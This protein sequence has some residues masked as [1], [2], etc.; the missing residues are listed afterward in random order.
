VRLTA[1]A[2]LK[3]D[4]LEAQL[5]DGDP[6]VTVQDIITLQGA[7]DK[8]VPPPKMQITVKYADAADT[9]PLDSAA[10]DNLR[11][12]R[13]CGWVPFDRDRVAKCYGCSWRSGDDFDS[14]WQPLIAPVD[15]SKGISPVSPESL[16]TGSPAPPNVVSIEEQRAEQAAEKRRLARIS[17]GTDP[18]P[19]KT[20][21]P[22]LGSPFSNSESPAALSRRISESYR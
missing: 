18:G 2:R 13:R 6:T 16:S 17:N 4:S 19:P 10:V 20:V 14:P 5:L 12:C 3:L 22:C 15:T 21:S 7:F 1:L 9:A 11:A 8:Y